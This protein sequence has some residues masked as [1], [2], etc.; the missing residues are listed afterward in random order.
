MW[1]SRVRYAII[2]L[3]FVNIIYCSALKLASIDKTYKKGLDAYAGE[4][5][6]ECIAKFEETLHLYKLHRI[7]LINCRLK[8]DSKKWKSDIEEIEDVK[9]YEKFLNTRL[10]IT[11]CQIKGFEDAHLNNMVSESV[12]NDMNS[13]KPYEYLHICYFQMNAFPKAASA[14]FT[15]LSAN[16]SDEKMKKN[17][18]YYL[19]QPEVDASEVVD[20]ESEVYK[21]LYRLG[22]KEY[23]LK[24]WA[25]TAA[26]MEETL[27]DY[28][29]WEN[30]CRAECQH[31]S[32]LEWSPE[33]SVTVSNYMMSLV[34][35]KQNCQ[36]KLEHLDFYSG[37]DFLADVLNY[38][39]I[40]YYNLGRIEDAAKAVESYLLL[41]PNDEDML[42][43]KI[44]YSSLMDKNNFSKRSDITY[45]FKR[46]KYEK[47]ILDKFYN[48]EIDN[49]ILSMQE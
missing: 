21:I 38:L 24:K 33:Y 9:V 23:N 7:I 12:I 18:E 37:N 11:D 45:Y 30:M 16:P 19:D 6:S 17:L 32:E 46:D 31:Q 39:Q 36:K 27:T 5:W 20:F 3:A 29:S 34:I 40:S 4:R 28:L 10:C 49:A 43:N 1:A 13:K 42:S 22:I 25:E 44:I 41:I 14:A 47:H 8:C 35:C 26:N 48:S 2:F 15:Y